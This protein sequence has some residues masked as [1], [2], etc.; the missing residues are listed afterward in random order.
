MVWEKIQAQKYADNK[1]HDGRE[2][3]KQS[4]KIMLE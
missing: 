2:R 1:C 3:I 4:P